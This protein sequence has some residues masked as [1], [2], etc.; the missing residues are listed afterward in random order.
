MRPELTTIRK[1]QGFLAKYF[2]ATRLMGAAFLSERVG[3]RIWLKLETDLPTG[4]FKVR[5][6]LWALAARLTR[7]R[8]EE[9]VA[10]STGNHGA[11]VAY[12]GKLL[13]VKARIFLPAGCNPVKRERIASLEAEIVEC[14]GAD[15][16][17]AFEL[18]REYAKSSGVYLLNDATDVDLPAGPGTIGSEILEQLPDVSAIVVPMGDTALIRGIAAAVKQLAPQVKIIGVQAEGA[19]AYYRSWKEDRVVGTETCDTI[20]DGLATRTPDAANVRDV[21]S[22]VD[23]VVLVSDEA[24]LQAIEILLV[25]EHVLAEPAGAASTAALLAARADLGENVVLVVSGANISREV[26]RRAVGAA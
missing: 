21:K 2:A 15:L 5:G 3:K 14:G 8:V 23:D 24:M 6:A 13:G 7:G 16:A 25:E 12:A 9:V 11:G 18:A 26:L 17:A 20:A 10:S 19:P 22:S 1:A 4:S